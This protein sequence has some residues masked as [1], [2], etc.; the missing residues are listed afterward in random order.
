L[1]GGTT[2]NEFDVRHC[3]LALR[4]YDLTYNIFWLD[5]EGMGAK[6]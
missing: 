3:L 5:F 6:D 2:P 4:G 1:G